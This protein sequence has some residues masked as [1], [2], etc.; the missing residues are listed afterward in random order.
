MTVTSLGE[1]AFLDD[2]VGSNYW[3]GASN[4]ADGETWEWINGENFTYSRWASG[5]PND[6]I[7]ND[8]RG[9]HYLESGGESGWKSAAGYTLYPFV[10]EFDDATP[11]SITAQPKDQYVDNGEKAVVSLKATGD[12]LTYQWYLKNKNGK[13]FS[14]SSITK[15][16]Y[17][18]TMSDTVN[19]RQLYCVVTDCYGNSLL[20][21][22]VTLNKYIPLF[23]VKQPMDCTVDNGAKATVT[24]EAAGVGLTYQWYLKNK[25]GT[26]FSK[27]SITKSTYSIT[28]SDTVDGRM[29]YCV[30]SDSKGNSIGSNIVTLSKKPALSIIE[31]PKDAY[32]HN[33]Q[34]ARA[35]VTAAGDGLTYQWYLK[36][37]NGKT[38]SKSSI[39]KNTYSVTMSDAVD[40][41]QLYCVVSDNKGYSVTTDIVTL[42]KAT[43]L[44]I[45]EQPKDAY[46]PN[47][48]TACATVTAAGDGLTYQWY[49]KNKNGKTFA[50]S[51]IK[52]N[53]YSVTMSDAVDGR[54]VYCIVTDSS[55]NTVQ[56]NTVTLHKA[57]GNSFVPSLE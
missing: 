20:S 40:G 37:K 54:Q 19:G 42:H 48:Q 5:E 56:T 29:V 45:I 1:D 50:K 30:V 26:K 44:S 16:T 23:V 33:G 3:L 36:N 22:T 6:N 25:N 10:C 18:V 14:K 13:T 43:K 4:A 12:G 39:K 27:S 38:F 57:E 11:V 31:Q 21:N 17:S 2:F 9:E 46:V 34:T 15:S 7:D 47:G 8:E 24:V 32:V 51:S 55:G 41:R 52:K 28:M 53:T 35:T 49:L